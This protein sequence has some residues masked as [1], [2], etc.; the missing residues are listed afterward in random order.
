VNRRAQGDLGELSAAEWLVGAGASVFIPLGHSPDYDLVADLEGRLL[1]VQVKTSGY[2]IRGRWNVALA[3]RGGNQ[4]WT[5]IVKRFSP[6]RADFLFVLV[7]DGRRWF[8]PA[9]EIDGGTGIILGGPKY[10][11]FEVDPGRP[12]PAFST[13]QTLSSD[14]PGGV[15]ER[16][17][18]RD[19][20]SRGSA[21][22]GSNPAPTI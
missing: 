19:C 8:I 4:S 18:G 21:F 6:E 2:F 15:P 17:K 3:T 10:A 1:R 11:R 16:S 7:A 14:V 22:A 12:F 13:D 5:G 20:K 9:R